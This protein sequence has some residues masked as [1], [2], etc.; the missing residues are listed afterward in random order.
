MKSSTRRSRRTAKTLPLLMAM[1]VALAGC[2]GEDS[3]AAA[4]SCDVYPTEDISLVVP[5]SAGG[6]FDSWARLMAPYMEEYLGGK[7]SVRV[8]NVDGGG[9]MRA[10]NEI[11]AA[12][13]D[14][15][16]LVF[17]EPGFAAVNQILGRA[18]GDFDIT[19]LTYIGQATVDPQVFAVPSDSGIDSI[20]DLEGESLKHAGQ[21]IS[22][23]ETIT[24][25]TFGVNGEFI[26]HDATSETILALRRGDSDI[27]V[28]SLSS[29]IEY[30]K[31]GDLKPLLFVGTEE[32]TPD[33]L[34]YEILEGTETIA[35]LGHPE[36]GEVL[37]QYR[38][39][40]GP[41]NLPDCITDIL[42]EALS[43]TLADEEFV[44]KAE[45]ADLRVIPA[46]AD[47]TQER[48]A[49]TYETFDQYSDALERAIG[50]N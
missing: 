37:E 32:I 42:A 3:E 15:T 18:G 19:K 7:I 26:L 35:D 33:L 38:V 20:Q 31:P 12:K 14:G 17:T 36:L 29:M 49:A 8:E 46:G 27:T 21:D 5:Y 10:M 44:A 23:I 30:L 9:G 48:V 16:S 40:A 4:A 22:P 47:E 28:A 2:G 45:E 50:G 25:D 6:G 34:G 39:L 13:A 1:G 24:Y 41:P 11:N 43:S